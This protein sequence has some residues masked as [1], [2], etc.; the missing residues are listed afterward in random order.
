MET[1][2]GVY[3][4]VR[5]GGHSGYEPACRRTRNPMT[6]SRAPLRSAAAVLLAVVLGTAG[7][8]GAALISYTATLSG[9]AESPPNAS[10]G[11]GSTQVDYDST[12][13][14]LRVRAT[15]SGLTGT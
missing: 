4:S 9:P 7:R 8:A 13:H 1:R 2:R 14:T 5:F 11:T 12:A 10:P 3:G 6:T 15:F